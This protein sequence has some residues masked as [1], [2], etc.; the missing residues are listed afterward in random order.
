MENKILEAANSASIST[1]TRDLLLQS[2]A[3]KQLLNYC[4]VAVGAEII[5]T[6][7]HPHGQVATAQLYDH[8]ALVDSLYNALDDFQ[9]EIL[10]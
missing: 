6:V 4:A 1:D 9:Q 10:P 5:I 7:K 2:E 3:V 8:A